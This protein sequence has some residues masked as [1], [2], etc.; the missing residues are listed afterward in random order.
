MRNAVNVGIVVLC[1]A[2]LAGCA[3]ME[4][5]FSTVAN[6]PEAQRAAG[7]AVENILSGNWVGAA[8]HLGELL[9]AGV[10]AVKASNVIR[11][12]R[13][14]QRGEQVDTGVAA[15]PPAAAP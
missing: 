11:D 13:R 7:S 3:A 2:T 15:A 4:G 1:C 8:Y 14:K 5:M 10:S 12:R 6:D 9:I